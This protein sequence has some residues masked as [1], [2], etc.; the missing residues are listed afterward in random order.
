MHEPNSQATTRETF[1]LWPETARILGIGRNAVYDAARRGD[2]RT[3]RVG[4]RILVPKSEIRRLLGGK[5]D[6]DMSRK[7]VLSQ[8]RGAE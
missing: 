3:I 1:D 7:T 5:P 6:A 2:F 8:E 4:K